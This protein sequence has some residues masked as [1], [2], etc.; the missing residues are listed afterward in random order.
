M[1]IFKKH[2]ALVK[3][4]EHSRFYLLIGFPCYISR[5]TFRLALI[6]LVAEANFCCWILEQPSGSADTLPDHP[7]LDWVFNQVVYVACLN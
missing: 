2:I 6:L 1:V 4:F 5:P 7:R 3:I